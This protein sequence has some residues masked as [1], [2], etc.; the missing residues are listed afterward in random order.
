[1]IAALTP[2]DACPAQRTALAFEL[3]DIDTDKCDMISA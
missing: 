1:M 3:A 2:I